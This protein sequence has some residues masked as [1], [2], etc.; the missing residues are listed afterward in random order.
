MTTLEAVFA[1]L[2]GEGLLADP[3]RARTFLASRS[4][5]WYLEAAIALA[6]LTGSLFFVG[7]IA[8][9]SWSL[10]AAKSS[11]GVWIGFGRSFWPRTGYSIAP[12]GARFRP[13]SRLPPASAV[14]P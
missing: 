7:F 6:A 4:R 12:P 14:W 8:A 10:F 3:G 9:T 11:T 13:T 5:V 2:E 1:T